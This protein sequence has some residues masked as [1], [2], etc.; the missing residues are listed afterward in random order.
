[1]PRPASNALIE[2]AQNMPNYL[3]NVEQGDEVQW[4]LNTKGNFS[5]KS[6]WQ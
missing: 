2:V 1:M 6:L 5:V 4:L 3:P